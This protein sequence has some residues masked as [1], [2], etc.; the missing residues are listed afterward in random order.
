MAGPTTSC[1]S[2]TSMSSMRNAI[3]ISS[4]TTSTRLVT[5]RR[6]VHGCG[7]IDDAD[8]PAWFEQDFHLCPH[9]A[10]QPPLDEPRPEPAP[11]RRCHRRPP[12]FAPFQPQPLA[13]AWRPVTRPDDLHFALVGRPRPVLDGVRGQLMQAE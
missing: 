2:S 3:V 12:A 8:D 13:G 10:G 7:G 1:P 6:S 5:S 4:S 11:A 9:L